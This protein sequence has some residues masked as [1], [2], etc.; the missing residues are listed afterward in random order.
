DVFGQIWIDGVTGGTEF[1]PF[2]KAQFGGRPFGGEFENDAWSDAAPNVHTG[3]NDEYWIDDLSLPMAGVYEYTFRFSADGGATWTVCDV[4]GIAPEV[5]PEFGYIKVVECNTNADCTDP[6]KPLCNAETNMCVDN[7]IFFSE[8]VEGGGF[9]KAI[10][11]YNG[12]TNDVDSSAYTLSQVTNGGTWGEVSTP[13]SGTLLTGDVYIIC[14]S[15]IVDASACDI[16]SSAAANFNG[17]DA[18][19]IFFNGIIIDQ[20]GVEGADPGAGWAVAGT[21]DATANHTLVRKATVFNGTTDWTASAGTTI[22]DS[23]WIV[24]DVDTLSYLGTR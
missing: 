4:N 16:T 12:S 7:A 11:I 20:I 5:D 3:N 21:A 17:D 2:I 13:L 14:H 6:A 22:E 19:A 10:E 1:H 15:D 8:Y 24:Y 9:N 18:L 23:E